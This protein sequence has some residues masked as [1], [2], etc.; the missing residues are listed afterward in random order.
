MPVGLSGRFK[1]RALK[2][3][4]EPYL[5]VRND[6]TRFLIKLFEIFLRTKVIIYNLKGLF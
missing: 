6:E 3:A 1:K 5:A 2:D 4:P